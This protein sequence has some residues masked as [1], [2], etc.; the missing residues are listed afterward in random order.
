[1]LVASGLTNYQYNSFFSERIIG[2]IVDFAKHFEKISKFLY[3]CDQD[4]ADFIGEA[5][6]AKGALY[7]DAI[8]IFESVRP[9]LDAPPKERSSSPNSTR[10]AVKTLDRQ[11]RGIFCCC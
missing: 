5:Q 1:M 3:T 6:K 10:F 11:F 2:S 4:E 7:C 9:N 8:E